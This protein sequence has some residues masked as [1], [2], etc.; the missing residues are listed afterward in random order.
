MQQDPT[1]RTTEQMRLALVAKM[2][3]MFPQF[4]LCDGKVGKNGEHGWYKLGESGRLQI[5]SNDEC[6]CFALTLQNKGFHDSLMFVKE[7]CGNLLRF[8]LK[9]ITTCR[10]SSDDSA[11]PVVNCI[12]YRDANEPGF[13]FHIYIPADQVST[14]AAAVLETVL[15]DHI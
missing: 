1:P 5:V 3:A 13:H 11:L 6:L 14:L 9:L 10:L 8:E 12:Q 7:E 15:V 2:H 4:K